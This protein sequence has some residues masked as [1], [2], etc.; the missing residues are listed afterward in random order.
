MAQVNGGADWKI[1]AVEAKGSY[2]LL[3]A[4]RGGRVAGGG[5]EGEAW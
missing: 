3:E 5:M 1:S 2:Q 4:V